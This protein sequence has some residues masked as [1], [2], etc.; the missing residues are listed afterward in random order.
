MRNINID[1]GWKFLPGTYNLIED[2]T[3]QSKARLVNLPHDFMLE[4]ETSQ[5]AP[6]GPAMGYYKG[7][8]GSYTKYLDIPLEWKDEKIYLHFDGVMLNASVEINGSTAALHH[9]GYTPFQV[10][11]TPYVD[12]GESNRVTVTV[13]ASMQPNSRWYTGAGIYRSV[14]LVHTPRVHLAADGIFAYTKRIEYMDG[15]PHEAFLA[16]EVTVVNDTAENHIVKVDVLLSPDNHSPD[17]RS[18]INDVIRSSSLMVRAGSEAKALIPV[19]VKDPA[20]WDAETPN[21]YKLSAR[22]TDQGIFRTN[23]APV[24]GEAMTDSNTVLFGIRTVTADSTYGLLVNGKPV[25]L[26]GGCI[27]HDNGVMGAVS[28]YDSEYRKLKIHKDNGYNAVRTAHNPPSAAL[29][30]AC[31]RLGLY[32]FDEAFDAWGM[33]KQPGDYNQFFRDHWKEDIRAFILRDRCHPCVLIWSTGNEIPERGGLGDGYSLAAEL[34]EYVRSLDSTRLVSNAMCSYWSGLDDG[35]LKDQLA[36]RQKAMSD[37]AENTQNAP[38]SA[39]N[40]YWEDRSEAFLSCLD[41]VGYNYAEDRYEKAGRMYPERVI[42]GTESFPM[43]IDRV[44]ELVEK[45]PYVIGDFTWTSF[46]YIGEAGIGKSVY[47]ESDDPMVQKDSM[48]ILWS[49]SSKYPWRLANDAD[50]DI[51]GVTMPQGNYRKIVW[52]SQETFLYSYNPA[53]YGKT[54]VISKWGWPN[55]SAC[56]NWAGQEGKPVRVV[57]YSSAEETELFLNGTSLGRRPAGKI[58][59]FTASFDITYQPGVLEAVSYENGTEVSR[60]SMVTT[61]APAAIR[62]CQDENTPASAVQNANQPENA[63]GSAAGDSVCLR[64]DG[65]SLSYISVEIV[66]AQGRL[67]PDASIALSAK[68]T[69]SGSLAGFGSANP[70]TSENYTTGHFTSY[71][72]RALAVIRSGYAPGTVTLTIGSDSLEESSIQLTV[73]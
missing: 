61:G 11:I 20:L 40:T 42:A 32:V 69:G 21:L 6:A 8:I 31:D 10:D 25:K 58:R 53:D 67:V 14:E 47:L 29:L 23:L 38:D 62:L 24:P 60:C 71:R 64:A 37:G 43:E 73:K 3:G 19:T 5:E 44:W 48:A 26:K 15:Q 4:G 51:N 63:P 22:L 18:G 57:V 39:E 45:L 1:Q 65:S 17:Q 13:N 68:V 16:A 9:Y 72:G 28:L 35:S 30:E 66:D 52:G 55:V 50:F 49:H 70:V 2:L 56:W 54:E 34:A 7:G 41:V 46:D 27:H 59:R 33:A 36:A 12:F